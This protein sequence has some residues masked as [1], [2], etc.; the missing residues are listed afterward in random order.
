MQGGEA[1]ISSCKNVNQMEIFESA[2]ARK[3]RK[4]VEENMGKIVGTLIFWIKRYT[5]GL[6]KLAS[7]NYKLPASDQVLLV[8]LT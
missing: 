5:T 8:D 7:T 2:I 6:S 4:K 1:Y 3:R